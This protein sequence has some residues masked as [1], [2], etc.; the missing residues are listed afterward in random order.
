MFNCCYKN[1]SKEETYP[2]YVYS[3]YYNPP[4]SPYGFVAYKG[5]FE[6]EEDAKQYCSNNTDRVYAYVY[7]HL[8]KPVS[9]SSGWPNIACPIFYK[10]V[11]ANITQ[12]FSE[13]FVSANDAADYI[14][15]HSNANAQ[16]GYGNIK[17]YPSGSFVLANNK[18]TVFKSISPF[19]VVIPDNNSSM[20]L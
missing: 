17:Y 16:F 10:D 9:P 14:Q 8:N 18:S 1:S 6:L 2:D 19:D 12:A 4:S 20:H 3:V 7:Q 13:C 11:K 5:V 15:E